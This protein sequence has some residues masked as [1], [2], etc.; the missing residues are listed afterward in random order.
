[1]FNREVCKVIYVHAYTLISSAL[2]KYSELSF[3]SMLSNIVLSH[4]YLKSA[5]KTEK[6]I[7]KY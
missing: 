5:R 7:P 3:Q 1:M 6:N 2:K 4:L